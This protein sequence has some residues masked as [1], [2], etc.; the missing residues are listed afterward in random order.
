MII[1]FPVVT[2]IPVFKITRLV[3]VFSFIF[4]RLTILNLL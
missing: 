3:F 2:I 1:E 4:P